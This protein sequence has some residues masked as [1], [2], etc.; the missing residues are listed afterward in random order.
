MPTDD[1]SFGEQL[2][3]LRL[4]KGLSLRDVETQSGKSISNPYLSQ[5]E[6]GKI[7][8]PSPHILHKLADL[9]GVPYEMLMEAAGYLS[10]DKGDRGGRTLA[11]VALRN[12][13]DLTPEEEAA[14]MDYI[15][16]IRSKRP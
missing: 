9:Y 10:R 7:K 15:S 13:D 6:N 16:F 14:V 11:G 12:L 3:A 8:K 2:R 5:L 1:T 4:A